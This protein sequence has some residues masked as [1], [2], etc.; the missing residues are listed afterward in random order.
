MAPIFDNNRALFPELDEDQL[1][2][3][4]WY[5]ERCHPK[6]RR[7]FVL[8][9][10]A[11]LTDEIRADMEKLRDFRFANHPQLPISETRLELL[12]GLVQH[13]LARILE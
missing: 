11:L 4:S 12:N 3:P 10:R 8:T 7:D 9:A 13:Q 5:I 1:T 2:D 6:L